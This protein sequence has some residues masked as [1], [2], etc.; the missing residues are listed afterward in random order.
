MTFPTATRKTAFLA[1]ISLGLLIG[2]LTAL[3]QFDLISNG[4][5]ESVFFPLVAV[6]FFVT[7]FV[8]VVGVSSIAPKELK[9][10]IPLVYFPTDPKG[11]N[12]LFRVWGR[13]LV[14]FLGAAI[15]TSF[16]SLF[17]MFSK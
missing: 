16:L 3:E 9:T 4:K 12:F 8:F 6:F 11:W 15:C 10:G 1:G 13:M 7:V 2:A 14:W 5:L 17:Q